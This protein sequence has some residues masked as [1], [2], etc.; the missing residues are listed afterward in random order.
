MCVVVGRL[1]PLFPLGKV[2]FPGQP[3]P[4][5]ASKERDRQLVREARGLPGTAWFGVI[6]IR[7]GRQACQD[8]VRALHEIGCVAQV[9]RAAELEDGR[10]VLVTKGT[11]RF[12]L[13]RLDRSRPYLQGEIDLLAEDTGDEAAAR[14]AAQVVRQTFSAYLGGPEPAPGPDDLLGLP[15]DP[16][17]L[18]YLVADFMTA[19]LPAKQSLLAEPDALSR[20]TAE[21]QMLSVEAAIRRRIRSAPMPDFLRTSHSRN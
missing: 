18:S 11:R 3:V 20:L 15:E 7:E 2:L 12:R 6:A 5:F 14:L 13:V 8:G 10:F 1:L 4:V 19:N 21:R 17:E 16:I 9:S